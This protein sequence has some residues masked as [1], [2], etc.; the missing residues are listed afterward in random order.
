M[1]TR[2][3]V[4]TGANSGIGRAAA[5]RFAREK[6]H[7]I[8]AC[9]SLERSDPVHREV[10][11]ASGNERVELMQVDVSSMSSIRTFS[12]AV[13]GRHPVIDVLI[14]NAAYVNHGAPY[15]LSDDGIELTFATN[16]LGPYLLTTGLA[17]RLRRSDDARILNA[18]SN[19]VKHFFNPKLK[20]EF[21]NLRGE[22]PDDPSFS[23]YKRYRDSKMALL[24]LTF[25]MAERLD[26]EGIRVNALQIN[27]ATMSKEAIRRF[28][29]KY[30]PIAHVQNLFF[31]P[32]ESVAETYYWL[33]T[34]EELTGV[35]G[36]YFN[37][38]GEIMR[39]GKENPGLM[40]Q[41][42][43]VVGASVYPRYAEQSDIAERLWS[44]CEEVTGTRWS[45]LERAKQAS[46]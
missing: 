44:W 17:D 12:E 13:A 18:G 1:S 45:R 43:Q 11:Q 29:P 27:G 46:L 31:R 6:H 7:V 8:M 42:K 28:S 15:R 41:I 19:I 20:I 39:V 24:I 26:S 38:R 30:R 34:A 22:M 4:I 5:H 14:N 16:V 21:E 3:V 23:V 25:E 33:C 10:V 36:E 35:S 32:P 2:T 9:R 40:D 37:H